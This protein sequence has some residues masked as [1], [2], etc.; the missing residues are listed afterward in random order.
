MGKIDLDTDVK[1][2]D[3]GSKSDTRIQTN[4]ERYQI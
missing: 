4:L 3:F 1:S 2:L